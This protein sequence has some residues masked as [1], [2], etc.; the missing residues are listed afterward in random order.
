[1]ERS[2]HKVNSNEPEDRAGLPAPEDEFISEELIEEWIKEDANIKI[3]ITERWEQIQNRYPVIPYLLSVLYPI[4]LIARSLWSLVYNLSARYL[5]SL[6]LFICFLLFV[7]V[8]YLRPSLAVELFLVAI[9]F[10]CSAIGLSFLDWKEGIYEK[11]VVQKMHHDARE[12]LN[13]GVEKNKPVDLGGVNLPPERS[14]NYACA[15]IGNM[16]EILTQEL[17]GS[18]ST[19]N[20]CKIN[21]INVELDFIGSPGKAS[22]RVKFLEDLRRAIGLPV[23]IKITPE[24]TKGFTLSFP[25]KAIPMEL[26]FSGEGEATKET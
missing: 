7:M 5:S 13:L 23:Q 2:D 19:Y 12:Q 18:R 11:V 6:C 15:R 1:M 4:F 3:G 14:I 17:W 26:Y 25:P 22:D 20:G 21:A 10:I 16:V 8:I 9:I 24:G